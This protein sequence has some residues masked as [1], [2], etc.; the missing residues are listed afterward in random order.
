MCLQIPLR[1]TDFHEALSKAVLKQKKCELCG[2]TDADHYE[3]HH[4]H[5]AKYIKGKVIWEQMM[6]AKCR[7]T[8]VVCEVCHTS[9]HRNGVS[10]TEQ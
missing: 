1:N 8:M 4:L 5:K 2:C 7:K 6:I 10:K 3:I 9:I